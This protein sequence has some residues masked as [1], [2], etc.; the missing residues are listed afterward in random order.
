MR[1]IVR[2]WGVTFCA[3]KV[4]LKR[5]SQFLCK[6]SKKTTPY[7]TL[8]FGK[9]TVAQLP[10][11]TA[12]Y[13]IRIFIT[14]FTTAIGPHSETHEYSSHPPTLCKTHF[15]IILLSILK[16]RYAVFSIQVFK[17]YMRL[18]YVMRSAW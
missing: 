13:W 7:S 4:K 10:I 3:W 9:L 17:F 16:C 18:S 12:F 2:H 5:M 1:T 8:R 14:C 6:Y 11:F 15:N